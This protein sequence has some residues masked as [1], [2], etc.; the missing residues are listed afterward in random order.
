[1]E[2]SCYHGQHKKKKNTRVAKQKSLSWFNLLNH[3]YLLYFLQK[4]VCT[5]QIELLTVDTD[6]FVQDFIV[7]LWQG[8][9]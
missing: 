8:H 9:T 7:R 1:M 4:E 5:L 2:M 3:F 6:I